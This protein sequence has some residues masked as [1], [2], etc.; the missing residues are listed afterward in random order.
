MSYAIG[1][2]SGNRGACAQPCRKKYSLKENNTFIVNNQSI[3]SMKDLCTLE[4]ID[5]VISSGVTSFKIEG[6]MRREEYTASATKYVKSLL[7]GS[8]A[9]RAEIS[10][11]YN[12]GDYTGG[13]FFGQD[14]N[15]ISSK[16]Q[17]HK[18]VKIG[19]ITELRGKKLFIRSRHNP[20][21]GDG[22]KIKNRIN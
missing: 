16:I 6:R 2:R 1:K 7:G 11:I 15:L 12:R 5:K 21:N 20:E 10:R 8:A 19:T 18:G 13:Y 22:F 9:D 14:K 4:D 17:N 3:I